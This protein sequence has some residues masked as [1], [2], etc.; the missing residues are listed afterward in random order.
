MKVTIEIDNE[1]LNELA[2]LIATKIGA[3]DVTAAVADVKVVEAVDSDD[4]LLGDGD[5][6]APP[7]LENVQDAIRAAASRVGDKVKAKEKVKAVL[8]K[9]KA[10]NASAL[11]PEQF[12]DAIAQFEK[13]KK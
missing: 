3:A 1:V 11:K 4:D 7:T 13:L 6:K 5:A 8:A 12:A 10:E 2:E 9:F